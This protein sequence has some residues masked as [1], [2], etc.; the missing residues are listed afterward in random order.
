MS[1]E[2]EKLTITDYGWTDYV[3]G[4]LEDK[5]IYDGKPTVDGLRRIAQKILGP[6]FSCTSKVYQVPSPDNDISSTVRVRVK[7]ENSVFDGCANTDEMSAP[8]M[9][10]RHVVALV[11]TRAEGRALRKALNLRV[12]TKEEV[13]GNDKAVIGTGSITGPQIQAIKNQCKIHKINIDKLLQ[14]IYNIKETEINSLSH[15]QALELFAKFTEWENT[16]IPKEI[17]ND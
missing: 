6:I 15:D 16:E 1:E 2:Q 11:E 9:I 14:S 10:G 12:V 13:E 3:L 5:E 7:F 4:Q 17:L 8:Q